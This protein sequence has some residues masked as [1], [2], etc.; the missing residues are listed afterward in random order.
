MG[1]YKSHDD[2]RSQA[3][4]V[5]VVEIDDVIQMQKEEKQLNLIL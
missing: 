3:E 2:G 1:R 5:I 4:H